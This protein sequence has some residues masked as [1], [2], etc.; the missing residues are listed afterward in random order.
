MFRVDLPANLSITDGSTIL[1]VQGVNMDL[2]KVET[3][4][5]LRMAILA[6]AV[7]AVSSGAKVPSQVKG[8]EG[9]P[10]DSLKSMGESF[11]RQ[12]EEL[13]KRTDEINEQ[14]LDQQRDLTSA[15]ESAAAATGAKHGA[16]K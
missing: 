15:Y 11:Q 8:Q 7:Q 16:G 5:D 6:L 9:A 3:M 10:V 1:T 14:I 4:D 13:Q 2:N 12:S